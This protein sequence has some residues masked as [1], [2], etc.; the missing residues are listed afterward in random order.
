MPSRLSGGA[1]TEMRDR[2]ADR[3]ASAL[4]RLLAV[5]PRFSA[6]ERLIGYAVLDR[7]VPRSEGPPPELDA[8]QGREAG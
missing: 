3:L 8:E 6:A 4:F 5:H 1:G 7:S 2:R